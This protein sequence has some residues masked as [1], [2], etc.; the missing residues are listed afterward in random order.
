MYNVI[1]VNTETTSNKN[2]FSHYLP[3]TKGHG[4]GGPG[5]KCSE[6]EVPSWETG[7]GTKGFRVEYTV[8]TPHPR[9]QRSSVKACQWS[10][11]CRGPWKKR[12]QEAHLCGWLSGTLISC[13]YLPSVPAGQPGWTP[14]RKCVESSKAH[15]LEFDRNLVQIPAL[16]SINW[17]LNTLRLFPKMELLL[18]LIGCWNN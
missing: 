10:C 13:I 5:H 4:E 18:D 9:F 7:T 16:P 6:T 15:A 17:E 1:W 11:V 2:I 8:R 3:L 12:V 14:G